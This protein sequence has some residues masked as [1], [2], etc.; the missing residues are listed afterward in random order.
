M[1]GEAGILDILVLAVPPMALLAFASRAIN[2]SRDQ[3]DKI[4][5]VRRA[6]AA[7]RETDSYNNW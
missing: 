4:D 1:S 6:L 5:A 3:A 7:R 2:A